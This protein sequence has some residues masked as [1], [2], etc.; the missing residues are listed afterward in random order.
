MKMQME[1]KNSKINICGFHVMYIF[2][3]SMSNTKELFMTSEVCLFITCI[4]FLPADGSL[5][6]F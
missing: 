1:M 3:Y 6:L 2:D 4:T 5:S